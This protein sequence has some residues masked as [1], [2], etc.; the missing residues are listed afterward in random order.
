MIAAGFI[1]PR[2]AQ[3]QAKREEGATPAKGND[4]GGIAHV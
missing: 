4:P 2:L 1:L 3:S